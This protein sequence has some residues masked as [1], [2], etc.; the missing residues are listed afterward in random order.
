MSEENDQIISVQGLTTRFGDHV[1]HEDLDLERVS[2]G[3]AGHSLGAGLGCMGDNKVHAA[4]SNI[5]HTHT[6]QH[7]YR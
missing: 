6:Q 3:I 2:S 4:N 1:V 7:Q 5:K